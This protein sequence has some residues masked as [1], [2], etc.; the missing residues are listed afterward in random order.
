M[1]PNIDKKHWLNL[2]NILNAKNSE[3]S[4]L[5]MVDKSGI[6][7]TSNFKISKGPN[8]FA[9]LFLPEANVC[10]RTLTL[11]NGK[12]V[13]IGL[14]SVGRKL[15]LCYLN[16]FVMC[17]IDISQGKMGNGIDSIMMCKTIYEKVVNF[18]SKYKKLVKADTAAA[19]TTVKGLHIYFETADD[20]S[21]DEN[22]Y[23]MAQFLRQV[24]DGNY[25]VKWYLDQTRGF[26]D[27]VFGTYR[28]DDKIGKEK[29]HI[30]ASKHVKK[31]CNEPIFV[32]PNSE[33]TQFLL[34]FR[35]EFS[36]RLLGLNC[37]SLDSLQIFT[38]DIDPSVFTDILERGFGKEFEYLYKIL[39][40]E[41]FSLDYLTLLLATF[42]PRTRFVRTE[43][44]NEKFKEMQK[45]LTSLF[46]GEESIPISEVKP[47]SSL[48]MWSKE[49]KTYTSL[50]RE[51]LEKNDFQMTV[52]E[53]MLNLREDI[54]KD[55]M[56][57]LVNGPVSNDVVQLL[58]AFDDNMEYTS[59][60]R[61]IDRM[62]KHDNSRD[63]VEKSDFDFF[64]SKDKNLLSNLPAFTTA[65]DLLEA[66]S[67]M[68]STLTPLFMLYIDEVFRNSTI[69][70]RVRVS[71]QMLKALINP[72]YFEL[73]QL[74]DG[75]HMLS[76]MTKMDLAKLFKVWQLKNTYSDPV[77]VSLQLPLSNI[78]MKLNG[79]K[80]VFKV[81]Y[82]FEDIKAFKKM[83]ETFVSPTEEELNFYKLLH[84]TITFYCNMNRSEMFSFGFDLKWEFVANY[85]DS[86]RLHSE[87]SMGDLI[88]IGGITRDFMT[89]MA[90]RLKD[91]MM[92]EN[93]IAFMLAG[94]LLIMKMETQ[95]QF[96]LPFF[97]NLNSYMYLLC[98]DAEACKCDLLIDSVYNRKRYTCESVDQMID[99]GFS[100]DQVYAQ[101][102]T[103]RSYLKTNMESRLPDFALTIL[104]HVIQGV[105]R[106]D[107]SNIY[108]THIYGD[109]QW[110]SDELDVFFKEGSDDEHDD[111]HGPFDFQRLLKRINPKFDNHGDDSYL[112][113]PSNKAFYLTYIAF[114]LFKETD[115]E[116]Y[117]FMNDIVKIT[118]LKPSELDL[119][120]KEKHFLKV[121]KNHVS[122]KFMDFVQGNSDV[123]ADSIMNVLDVQRDD[124]YDNK[125]FYT[126]AARFI[127]LK[128]LTLMTKSEL[129][130]VLKFATGMDTIPAF[131]EF[132]LK[133]ES[134]SY[135]TTWFGHTC[136]YSLDMSD[137][138]KELTNKLADTVI[139]NYDIEELRTMMH[140]GPDIYNHA[141][142]ESGRRS[143]SGR[144]Y[145]FKSKVKEEKER[146]IDHI[147]SSG[148]TSQSDT[149]SEPIAASP[150]VGPPTPAAP[151]SPLSTSR[152]T[153]RQPGAARRATGQVATSLPPRPTTTP[154]TPER[155]VS[156]SSSSSPPRI[157][158]RIRR[159]VNR[160]DPSRRDRMESIVSSI[161]DHYLI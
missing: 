39:T 15:T 60:T 128:M 25:V 9:Y 153:S 147:L 29:C 50:L 82:T 106:N 68:S 30:M 107:G 78:Q 118:K 24:C 45:S 54:Y 18:A 72:N 37:F 148:S 97:D 38:Q 105:S 53:Y 159:P 26:C 57:K 135:P 49:M 158:P 52:T 47:L 144:R 28:L 83:E 1:S 127:F 77:L 43:S 6:N 85:E 10:S 152:E 17:D 48:Q 23:E 134:K 96:T 109:A 141:Y 62:Y 89:S 51:K 36:F 56:V 142:Q 124:V 20:Y 160:F 161:L 22:C 8:D 74:P 119:N 100:P 27:K 90:P 131:P 32:G 117:V 102:D 81:Y 95:S 93:P 59:R 41:G 110:R 5:N 66:T 98:G 137:K 157:P 86:E 69:M 4:P 154:R 58:I 155:P 67:N 116:L 143:R 129:V 149:C 12:E 111:E 139:K 125:K 138:F 42:T 113:Q 156:S 14:R 84:N 75:Q 99:E 40:K 104:C 63:F 44:T 64:M 33:N 120:A 140:D 73:L 112:T 122:K 7:L 65:R 87:L 145:D 132:R 46:Y 103:L 123:T 151:P 70:D 2:L 19:V 13:H 35:R 133:L 92:R 3:D 61:V 71:R 16:G 11:P 121:I 136:F 21:P 101:E 114:S 34:K 115:A 150:V 130:N 88:D 126:D 94:D 76:K 146:L 79:E 108:H 31:A 80:L 91:L 55:T